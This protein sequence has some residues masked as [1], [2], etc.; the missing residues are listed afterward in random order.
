MKQY[1]VTNKAEKSSEWA[2][3][4]VSESYIVVYVCIC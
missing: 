4:D 1:V 2:F 3:P